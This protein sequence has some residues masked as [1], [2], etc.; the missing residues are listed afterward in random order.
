MVTDLVNIFK[1]A[2]S[3]ALIMQVLVMSQSP[4]VVLSS[5]IVSGPVPAC[6][7]CLFFK[8]LIQRVYDTLMQPVSQQH[9]QNKYIIRLHF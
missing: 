8:V 1:A 6:A 9:L 7:S 4:L 3:K 2:I 5:A